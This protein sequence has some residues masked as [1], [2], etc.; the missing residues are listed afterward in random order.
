SC[1]FG[2]MRTPRHLTQKTTV[3]GG[4][5]RTYYVFKPA[6]VSKS[7]K[8]PVVMVFH[9]GGGTALRMERWLKF[10]DLARREK[11]IAV[12]PDGIGNNWNDGRDTQVNRAHKDKIDDLS[13]VSKLLD[14][15]TLDYPVDKDRIYATGPSNGGIFSHFIAAQMADRIAAIAPVIGGIADPFHKRFEPSDPVS[16]FII[17]GTE[18][19]LVPYKGGEIGRNRGRVISTDETIRIWTNHNKTDSKAVEGNLADSDKND[20]CRVETFTW[21]NGKNG[22]E[23][24]LYKLIGGGHTWPGGSQYA[25]R[26]IVGRVC[27]DFDATEAVWQFFKD[28]PKNRDSRSST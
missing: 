2:Q 5:K 24:V 11:F 8:L 21:R 23:V 7:K 17:Q 22:T 18:D 12:Y 13:F 9:G 6:G 3:S 20:G 10:T 14:E 1:V 28:H 16:V 19:K 15:V 25:P 27:R 4:I 26:F